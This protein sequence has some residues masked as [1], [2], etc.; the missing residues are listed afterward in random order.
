MLKREQP[1]EGVSLEANVH[2][3]ASAVTLEASG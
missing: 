1:S 2:F 3:L